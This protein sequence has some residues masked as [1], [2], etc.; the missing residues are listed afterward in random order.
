MKYQINI[1]ERALRDMEAIYHFIGA[2]HSLQA[3][4][5][6]KRLEEAIY[7]L[8]TMPKRCKKLDNHADIRYLNFGIQP[9]S[10]KIIYQITEKHKIVNI[11]HIRH[12]ARQ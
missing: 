3:N 5:W 8:E 10:Y 7:S 11:L 9:H 6:F 4:E 12:G 1:S 2:A